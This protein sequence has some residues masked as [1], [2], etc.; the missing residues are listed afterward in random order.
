MLKCFN[1]KKKFILIKEN[2][3]NEFLKNYELIKYDNFDGQLYKNWSDEK[4]N[5]TDNDAIEKKEIEDEEIKNESESDQES[6]DESNEETNENEVGEN[7][8]LV[9]D[10]RQRRLKDY[11]IVTDDT[12]YFNH[13]YEHDLNMVDECEQIEESDNKH[14]NY[15]IFSYDASC[16]CNLL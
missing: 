4:E 16:I 15:D 11:E 5:T 12:D 2:K 9:E 13:E 8:I 6:I 7:E 10:K 3:K 14:I 1:L